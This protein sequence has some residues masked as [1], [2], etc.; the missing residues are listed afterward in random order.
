MIPRR[1]VGNADPYEMATAP[2]Q[3]KSP[4]ETCR[5]LRKNEGRKEIGVPE[6]P[7]ATFET[8]K[9][10]VLFSVSSLYDPFWSN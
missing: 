4:A 3:R 10:D 2:A 6:I 8:R 1:V 9:K 5:A 7:P